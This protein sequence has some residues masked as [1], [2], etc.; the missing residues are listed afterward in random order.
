MVDTGPLPKRDPFAT[1]ADWG[2]T[3][4]IPPPDDRVPEYSPGPAPWASPVARSPL[5]AWAW[6]CLTVGALSLIVAGSVAIT[7]NGRSG[8]V[9]AV[10]IIASV[11]GVST[12][13]TC[14][15]RIIGSYGLIATVTATNGTDQ[16]QT[17]T[18]WV[19]WPITGE[20]AKTFS[21]RVTLAPGEA[22]E[23]PVNQEIPAADWYQTGA[24]SYGWDP[25]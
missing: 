5:P 7:F 1:L 23:F 10:P 12:T 15:K 13:G 3:G 17:G 14:E 22:T 18:V 11:P 6:V 9:P 21:K 8:P 2:R 4:E 25:A 24:C 20:V 16:V 19:R